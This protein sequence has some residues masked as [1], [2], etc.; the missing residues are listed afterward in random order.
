MFSSKIKY[1]LLVVFVGLLS[2]LY[3]EYVMGIIFITV[4]ALPFVL[5]ALLCYCYKRVRAE[6]ASVVHVVT[7]GETVPVVVQL[8]NPTIFP[9]Y[10]LKIYL[11]Y[12]NSYSSKRYK[13]EFIATMDGRSNLKVSCNL[14]SE[15]SGNIEI[16]LRGIRCY[17]YLKLFSLKKKRKDTI[18]VA[19]LPSLIELE[20]DFVSNQGRQLVESE[21]YSQIK[22]GDDPSEVF[23]I[24]EYREGDRIQRIHWKL[25][26]KQNQLMIKE[27]SNP[28]NCAVLI[29]LDFDIPTGKERLPVTDALLECSLS[30]SY[31]FLAQKQYH[32]FSWY[33]SNQ[34]ICRR[35]RII[36][37]KD[38][39][40][41]VDGL[42][43]LSESTGN[44]NTLSTYLAC[45]PMEQYT[46][47][48]YI[49]GE[50][51]TAKIDTLAMLIANKKNVIQVLE[52]EEDTD[53]LEYLKA[54]VYEKG[55]AELGMELSLVNIN[56]LQSDIQNLRLG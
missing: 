51:S 35:N 10:G 21:Y 56:N 14:L 31:S 37:E 18:K 24:R 52:I 28:L 36:T 2:I 38:L 17:D 13:K 44:P 4:L 42:L 45:Y 19:V 27:F 15:Y 6:L 50:I 16:S 5:F 34:G 8:Y 47:I 20:E 53:A 48:F 40:E 23:S 22:S 41:V 7:K 30:L 12:K 3:N 11:T 54:Q 55:I 39:F 33:D 49:T 26:S 29:Y 32:Y 25:S 9:I 46:D 1:L 43:E